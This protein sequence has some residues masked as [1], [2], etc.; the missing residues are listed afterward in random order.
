MGRTLQSNQMSNCSVSATGQ[1]PLINAPT[2]AS[3]LTVSPMQHMTL[4]N[5][6]LLAVATYPK[7]NGWLFMKGLIEET[8][9]DMVNSR[10]SYLGLWAHI[11]NSKSERTSLPRRSGGVGWKITI[12]IKWRQSGILGIAYSG[13]DAWNCTAILKTQSGDLLNWFIH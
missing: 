6:Q 12:S 11:V 10:V 13:S 5:I 1:Q 3:V 8:K 2:S 4:C 7:L 9:L